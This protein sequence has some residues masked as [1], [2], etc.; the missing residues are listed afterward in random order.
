[1]T[2][3]HSFLLTKEKGR[4]YPKRAPSLGGYF[5]FRVLKY[6]NA[7]SLT[8][9]SL[10]YFGGAVSDPGYTDQCFLKAKIRA[11][12]RQCL[13][14]GLKPTL[15]SNGAMTAISNCAY[16]IVPGVVFQFR[17]AQQL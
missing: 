5:K 14:S 6:T 7:H 4:T 16:A 11:S 9:P 17:Q 10:A 13:E 3:G 15:E 1:M 12:E 2:L 8:V